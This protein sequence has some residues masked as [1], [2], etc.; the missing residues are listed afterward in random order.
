METLTSLAAL[1][2]VCAIIGTPTVLL[3]NYIWK[4][5]EDRKAK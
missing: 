3:G 2:I 1:I 4:K 5:L